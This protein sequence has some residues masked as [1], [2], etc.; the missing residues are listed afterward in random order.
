VSLQTTYADNIAA[1]YVGGLVNQEPQTLISRT[2]EDSGGIDFG[3]AVMQGSEDKGCV[4]GDGSD[5]LGVTVRDQSVEASDPDTFAYQASARIMTEGVIWVANSGGV[6]AGDPVAA[7]ADGALGTSSTPLISNAR[8]D[9][10]ADD[11][12]LAQLRLVGGG[13]ES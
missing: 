11:G 8:W 9:T 13:I 1:G 2:V 12:E 5:F 3:L 6:S 10:S 7:L 4:V